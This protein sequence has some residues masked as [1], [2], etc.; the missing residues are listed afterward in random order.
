[1]SWDWKEHAGLILGV[2]STLFIAIRLLAV[3]G[4]DSQ[5]AFAI[6]Q[7]SGT[8]S[9]LIGQALGLGG[10]LCVAIFV[11]VFN[12]V[13][14]NKIQ[15]HSHRIAAI[16]CLI[17]LTLV[18]ISVFPLLW[19]L[20][21]IYVLSASMIYKVGAR[22]DSENENKRPRK[23]KGW[24]ALARAIIYFGIVPLFGFTLTFSINPW[25]AVEKLEF[26]Q[27]PPFA[28][29]VLAVSPSTITVLRDDPR[30]VG[31]YQTKDLL[32]RELCDLNTD[33]KFEFLSRPLLPALAINRAQYPKCPGKS[34][35]LDF[36][37]LRSPLF[38]R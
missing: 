8:T 23:T 32:K 28:A 21:G 20:A 29:Y 11:V 9:V 10:P 16:A 34:S 1:M 37:Q 30:E 25:F 27:S 7:A 18:S 5:T 31:Y 33:T 2:T 35:R 19:T 38:I 17:F 14:H 12:L 26:A 15:E 22:K 6:L 4:F 24:R 3:S 13:R 36:R